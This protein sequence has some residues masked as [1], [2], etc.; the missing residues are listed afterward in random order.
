MFCVQFVYAD[1]G[2]LT[3]RQAGS[4]CQTGTARWRL[5]CDSL[6]RI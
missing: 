3:I 5:L 6:Q 1:T 2:R 4:L